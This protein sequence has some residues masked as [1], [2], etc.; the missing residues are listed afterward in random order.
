M[1]TDREK[2]LL[3]LSSKKSIFLAG[4]KGMVGYAL[5]KKLKK[6][7]DHRIITRSKNSLDLTIQKDVDLFFQEEKPDYVYMAA[8]KV[9]GINANIKY[10]AEFIYQ[11]L[12]IQNNIINS[13]Y[14]IGVEK[15]LFLGS[16]CI[17]PKNS[18]QPIKEEYLLSG[19]L[20]PTNEPYAIAKISGIKMCQSYYDQYGVNFVS[21]MPNNLYGPNDNFDLE[22]SHVLPALIRKIHDAKVNN[23]QSVEIWGTGLPLR[24]FLHVDDLADACIY[25]MENIDA[26]DIYGAGISHLN[27]GSGEEISIINLA[28]LIK[29]VVGY[30]GVIKLNSNYPDGMKRKL[31]NASRFSKMG[32]NSRITLH[33]GIH[34]VY[35][36]YLNNLKI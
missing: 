10:K 4:H 33:D 11:N 32:W 19:V 24:E 2:R 5:L 36:W 9:G 14:K 8:A 23:E 1:A 16:A 18:K 35:K 29:E 13:A 27:V 26:E 22:T 25:V 34:S 17:Y 21:I 28:K 31:L 20:E 12:M 15:L 7:S 30:S 3:V 6:K